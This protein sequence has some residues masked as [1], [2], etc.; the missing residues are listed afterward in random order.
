MG[1]VVT[2]AAQTRRSVE[3]LAARRVAV[4]DGLRPVVALLAPAQTTG[5]YDLGIALH[6]RGG[7][8]KGAEV[9]RPVAPADGLD[10]LTFSVRL[11][12]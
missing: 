9:V 12:R 4:R 1:L 10:L 3:V 2:E 5:G 7:A 6:K 11:S 8:S